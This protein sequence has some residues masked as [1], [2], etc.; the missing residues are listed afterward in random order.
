MI[1]EQSTYIAC[2]IFNNLSQVLCP[3]YR[4][5]DIKAWLGS[6]I[7]AN[8]TN[9][10][11]FKK[12]DSLIF[13]VKNNNTNVSTKKNDLIQVISIFPKYTFSEEIKIY[14]K[15]NLSWRA[16]YNKNSLTEYSF[17]CVAL[18]KGQSIVSEFR[19]IQ[20][21]LYYPFLII[22]LF[23]YEIWPIIEMFYIFKHDFLQM[24][25]KII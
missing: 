12:N 9:G 7:G 18:Y 3:L 19:T 1:K 25:N 11:T 23:F 14:S 22:V 20:V 8:K 10:K 5:N 21:S 13:D 24:R 16:L 2:R 15:K 6:I 4:S 17:K